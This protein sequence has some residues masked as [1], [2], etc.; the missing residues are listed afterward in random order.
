VKFGVSPFGIWKSGYPAGIRGMSAVDEIYADSRRWLQ[1]GWVDYLT[2]QLYW[3][4]SAPAQSYP[5]LL[6]WWSEQ[7]TRKRHLWPGHAAHRIGRPEYTAAEITNQLRMT[8]TQASTASLSSGDVLFGW[9]AVMQNKGGI[10]G[11]LQNIWQTPALVPP[12]PWLDARAPVAPRLQSTFDGTTGALNVSWESGDREKPHLWVLQTQTGGSWT[13]QI[14]SSDTLQ[15]QIVA[16]AGF[17]PQ[18]LALSAVDRC[19]NQSVPVVVRLAA[20]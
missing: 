3:P 1:E 15:T 18:S 8:R 13:T 10:A 2:P 11:A 5:V 12:S 9:G 19:G 7:N 4:V 17:W 14:L 16:A 6:K 20:S